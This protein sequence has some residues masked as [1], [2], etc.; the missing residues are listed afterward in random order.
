MPKRDYGQRPSPPKKALS[1]FLLFRSEVFENV[2]KENPGA[3]ITEI[4]LIISEM[5]NNVDP[6]TRE[7]LQE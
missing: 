4:T 6:Q 3:R 1:S 7:R 2:K 5:W